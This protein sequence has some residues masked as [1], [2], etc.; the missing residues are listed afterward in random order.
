METKSSPRSHASRNVVVPGAV[1]AG[2]SPACSPW[3]V[4]MRRCKPGRWIRARPRRSS[5]EH[6]RVHACVGSLSIFRRQPSARFPQDPPQA[7][8]LPRCARTPRSGMEPARSGRTI[9]R[10]PNHAL[11]PADRDVPRR[12]C[13]RYRRPARN[14]PAADAGAEKGLGPR[15]GTDMIVLPS[16]SALHACFRRPSSRGRPSRI[17]GVRTDSDIPR[18]G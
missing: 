7:D 10:T 3:R 18:E 8:P 11:L 16:G 17:T 5:A 14:F 12:R 4:A 6:H 15:G 13:R 9:R 1:G 2:G